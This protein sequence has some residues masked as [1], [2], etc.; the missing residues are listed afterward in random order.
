MPDKGRHKVLKKQETARV[1]ARD[2]A[3]ELI[4]VA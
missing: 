2:D 1:S 3:I 4:D